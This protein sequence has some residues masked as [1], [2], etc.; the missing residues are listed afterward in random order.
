M[1]DTEK[2]QTIEE[3]ATVKKAMISQPMAG[4]TDEEIAAARDLAV[5]KLRQMGYEVVNTLFTDEWYSDEAMKE[6]GVVQVPLCF[7]AKS[8]E[9]MSLCHAAY[10]CKG[11]E[12]AR[13]CKIEHEVAE[14]YGLEV[15][16]EQ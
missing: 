16:H 3:T 10:F 1:N 4:K 7:L 6:R 15:I 9:N 2:N 12:D 8:L 5:A 14:A 11:W 13:G